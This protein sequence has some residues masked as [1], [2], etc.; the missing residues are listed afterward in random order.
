MSDKTS[1]QTKSSPAPS[2]QPKQEPSQ[3]PRSATKYTENRAMKSGGKLPP[4]TD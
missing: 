1:N 2:Q 3:K 4:D